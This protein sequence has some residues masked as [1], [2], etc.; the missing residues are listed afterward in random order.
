MSPRAALLA[1]GQLVRFS[2]VGLVC[3][4]ASTSALAA[5]HDLAGLHYL[6]AFVIAFCFGSVLGYVLNGRFTF[7][8]RLSR[9]GVFRYVLLNGILLVV[10]SALMKVLVDTAHVWYIAASLLLAALSTPMSFLLHRS[11]SYAARLPRL[12]SPQEGRAVTPTAYDR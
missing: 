3:L 12:S 7:S 2:G 1:A 5:L 9:T 8:A 4:A 11:F 6:L 10:N